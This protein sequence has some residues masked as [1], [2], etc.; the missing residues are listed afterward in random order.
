MH[1]ESVA[2]SRSIFRARLGSEIVTAEGWDAG[3]AAAL[4]A[5]PAEAKASTT[6]EAYVHAYKSAN[7]GSLRTGLGGPGSPQTQHAVTYACIYAIVSNAGRVPIRLSRGDAAGTRAAW[8]LKHVRQG[9]TRDERIARGAKAMM[10][11]AEGEIVEGGELW[12]LLQRPNPDQTWTQFLRATVGLM[13]ATGRVHWLYDEMV[14]RRPRTMIPIPGSATRPVYDSGGRHKRLVGWEIR[15]PRGGWAPMLLEECLTFQLFNPDAI[16]EGL[17]PAD[18]A[19]LAICS[20]YNAEHF[21]AS[22]W[23][24]GAEP[25]GVLSTDGSFDREADEQIRTSWNQRHRGA[26]NARS[27]AVLWGG[28]RWETVASTMADQQYTEGAQLAWQLICMAYRV[29]PSVAGFFGTTGDSDAYLDAEQERFWQDTLS[30]LVDDVAEGVDVHIKP[31]FAGHDGLEVWADVEDVPIL[32]KLRRAAFRNV[33]ELWDMGVPLA[34]AADECN[35]YLPERPQHSIGFLSAS[36]APVDQL[37]EPPEPIDET[38]PP[39]ADSIGQSDEEEPDDENGAAGASFSGRARPPLRSAARRTGTPAGPRPSPAGDAAA[40]ALAERLWRAWMASW[41]PLSR[42]MAG[43]LRSVFRR[44]ERAVIAALRERIARGAGDGDGARVAGLEA[45]DSGGQ[46]RPLNQP[47]RAS[48]TF[49]GRAC[50]PLSGGSVIRQTGDPVADVLMEVFADAE[51]LGRFRTRVR[52]V[53]R[54]GKALGVRQ[55]LAEAG[56]SG[57]A[58]AEAYRRLM[59]EGAIL[60]QIRRE[61]I[62]ITTLVDRRTRRILREQLAEGLDA[63]E[64]VRQLTDRV[65]SVMGGRR[66]QANLIARNS[67]GQAVSGARHAGRQRYAT[68]EIWIHSRGPG[69]RRPAHVAAEA[70]YRKE[71]KV[72]GRPFIVNGAALRYPRDP[73]GPPG[74]IINCQCVAVG[75]VLPAGA[76][77]S[78]VEILADQLAAGFVEADRELERRA[79]PPAKRGDAADDGLA[80]GLA[81]RSP[82]DVGASTD[83]PGDGYG[84]HNGNRQDPTRQ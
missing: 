36:I 2:T 48:A 1:K 13:Y 45:G 84:E 35:V 43:V 72:V 38:A 10:R 25:G 62:R 68:H 29:P 27:V 47:P 80:A 73:A 78:V 30:V 70:R 59:A 33:R 75:K 41:R 53:V 74:E 51:A 42:R 76:Q 20:S 32:Q 82:T 6:W 60:D 18:P 66:R 44:Q 65:Q 4:T 81:P 22:M 40:R 49:S 34:D 61:T 19:R 79:S 67:V 7:E 39:D 58:L 37:L 24:N 23:N 3:K 16:H 11:A 55:A 9:R 71:P 77:W 5:L 50:P 14:G 17:P 54:S 15:L 52:A 21:A 8:G 28:L 69:E 26:A 12:E 56:L 64:D 46:A 31:L 63:S 83:A 57:E